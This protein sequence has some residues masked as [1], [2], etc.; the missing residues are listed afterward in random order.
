M[1]NYVLHLPA[2]LSSIPLIIVSP[3]SSFFTLNGCYNLSLVSALLPAHFS[4]VQASP[5]FYPSPTPSHLTVSFSLIPL[6]AFTFT[7]SSSE[8]VFH[9]PLIFLTLLSCV[10]FYFTCHSFPSTLLACFLP[11]LTCV[12]PLLLLCFTYFFLP[13][14][15]SAF[16]SN[17]LCFYLFL[18]SLCLSP[19]PSFRLPPLP[20]VLSLLCLFLTSVFQVHCLFSVL[21]ETV[22]QAVQGSY[23]PH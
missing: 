14:D 7:H 21:S 10:Q 17:G 19:F 20:L 2:Q 3:L 6:P 18:Y 12:C 13:F 11:L 8:S 22:A 1:C 23:Q 15:Y 9:P 16:P 5:L 4:S